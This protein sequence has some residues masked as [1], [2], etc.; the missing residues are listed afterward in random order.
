MRT[1]RAARRVAGVLA[2]PL[3]LAGLLGGAGPGVAQ[4]ATAG[5]Q[6][7][8]GAQPPSA[9][10]H[11]NNELHSIAVLSACNAWAV[12][13]FD[14]SSNVQQTLIEHWNGSN[15]KIIP[16]PSP[17]SQDNILFSVRAASPSNI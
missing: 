11:N 17:G 13:S 8:T 5:C 12:G 15:W 7:W 16:S 3:L 4:A 6:A 1:P 2:A 10:V 14:R 9:S